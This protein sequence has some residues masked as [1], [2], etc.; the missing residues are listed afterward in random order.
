[1]DF[2]AAAST[3]AP[4]ALSGAL[5]FAGA[6][7][8]YLARRIDKNVQRMDI[9]PTLRNAVKDCADALDRLPAITIEPRV[10]VIDV[11]VER[12]VL[13]RTQRDDTIEWLR[14]QIEALEHYDNN[15]PLIQMLDRLLREEREDA[16][17]IAITPLEPPPG[18]AGTKHIPFSK[19]Y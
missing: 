7:M 8:L 19:V 13:P 4:W 3:A 14:V 12:K 5:L 2:A 6:C 16:R 18:H 1:M 10:R 11:P 17:D 15:D 9:E